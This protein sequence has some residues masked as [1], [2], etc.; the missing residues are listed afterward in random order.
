MNPLSAAPRGGGNKPLLQLQVSKGQRGRGGKQMGVSS[1]LETPR[2]HC[3]ALPG[4]PQQPPPLYPRLPSTHQRDPSSLF[5]WRKLHWEES[6]F[7]CSD[8]EATLQTSLQA[9]PQCSVQLDVSGTPEAS[10]GFLTFSLQ[11]KIYSSPLC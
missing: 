1:S 6:T 3:G 10:P 2:G 5:H 8:P 7:T 4:G 9:S 11:D